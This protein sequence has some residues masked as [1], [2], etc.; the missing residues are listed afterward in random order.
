MANI[1]FGILD[2]QSPAKIGNAFI[3]SPE[4]QN[5]NMLQV[6]QMQQLM[7][8]REQAQY[9]LGKSRREETGLAAFGEG[10]RALGPDPDPDAVAQ[11]FIKHPDIGM[12]KTG[13]E[14]MQRSQANKKYLLLKQPGGAGASPVAAAPFAAPAPGSPAVGYEF[15]ADMMAKRA[16]LPTF[17]DNQLAATVAAP[18]APVTPRTRESRIAQLQTEA[19]KLAPLAL[20]GTFAKAERDDILEE[21][22][23]L[24]KPQVMAPGSVLDTPGV[25]RVTAPAAPSAIAR[26]QA[27]LEA[28]PPNDPRRP[29]LQAQVNSAMTTQDQGADRVKQGWGQLNVAQRNAVTNEARLKLA[30][31]APKLGLVDPEDIDRVAAGVAS[32][33]IPVARLN[34]TTAPMFAKL[35]KADPNLDFTNMGI[36]QAGATASYVASARINARQTL[37]D[38]DATQAEN[39]ARGNLPPATGPNAAKIMNE[40]VKLNPTYNARDFGLQTAAEK[41]FNT[42][43]NGNKT[44]SLNVAVSHLTTLDTAAVALRANDVRAFNEF[45]QAWQ[46]ET[47]KSAPTD[48]NAVRELVAD[49]IVAAVVPGVGALADRKA[50]KDTIVS[51]SSPEQLQG[52]IKQYKELL[53]GQLGGL[54]TQY[55]ASTRKTD[56]RQRYLTP[57]AIAALTPGQKAPPAGAARPD[58]V[59]PNWTFETDAK[60]NSA[61]VSPDRKSFKEAQ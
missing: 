52:V 21:I 25:D 48:F 23:G 51:K 7:D 16:A 38:V 22:K 37:T 9:A 31:E 45:K 2:T 50:L 32:G 26:M 29:A 42:G 5:A 11:L 61:W 12:Q 19:A 54:E 4:Q 41:E 15:G 13:I 17:G 20:P 1:N 6:M 24:R 40:V 57:E 53:G 3:R 10:L 8:Q 36:E 35:L 34:S 33:R 58:G 28:M 43:K 44:R 47:G 56:F 27:E 59:G 55:K 46:R 60:G 18:A 30:Q 49:E 14:L 39:I